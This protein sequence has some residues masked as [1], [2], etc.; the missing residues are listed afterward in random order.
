MKKTNIYQ[1]DYDNMTANCCG[2]HNIF[3]FNYAMHTYAQCRSTSSKEILPQ[4]KE[5]IL[6]NGSDTND[7]DIVVMATVAIDVTPIEWLDYFKS[8]PEWTLMKEF[9]NANTGNTVLIYTTN[10]AFEARDRDEDEDDSW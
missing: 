3:G 8:T 4:I 1:W 2:I 9:V 6:D 10:I 5:R 7:G